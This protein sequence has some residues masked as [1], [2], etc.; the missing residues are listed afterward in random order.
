[1]DW[2]L[3]REQIAEVAAMYTELCEKIPDKDIWLSLSVR[4]DNDE[5]GKVVFIYDVY[6][7]FK[8]KIIYI[9]M[10]EYRS[11][12]DSPITNVDVEEIIAHLKGDK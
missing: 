9:N 6:A 7:I 1:M 11:L 10:G 3:N 8:D 2:K 5:N 12:M 4:K